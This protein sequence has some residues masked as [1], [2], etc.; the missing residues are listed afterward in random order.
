MTPYRSPIETGP[1]ITALNRRTI[2]RIALAVRSGGDA[3]REVQ[4]YAL[5]FERITGSPC[6]DENVAR[7][8]AKGEVLADW[9]LE[10]VPQ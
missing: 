6:R 1:K 3:E 5:T 2:E 9:M 10:E 4:I 7:I 8:R